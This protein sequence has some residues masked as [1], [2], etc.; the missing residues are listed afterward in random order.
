MRNNTGE[1]VHRTAREDATLKMFSFGKC[2]S[3]T[4]LSISEILV[5][6]RYG[7]ISYQYTKIRTGFCHDSQLKKKENIDHLRIPLLT[8]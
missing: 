2:K 4:Q 8:G 7:L 3:E 1:G 5:G 6:I